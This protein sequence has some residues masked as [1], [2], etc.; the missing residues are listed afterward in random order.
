MRYMK[1]TLCLILPLVSLLCSCSPGIQVLLD[2]YNSMFDLTA[3]SYFSE[4]VNNFSLKSQYTTAN[5]STLSISAP[6]G[7]TSYEWLLAPR[8]GGGSN[9]PQNF[10]ISKYGGKTKDLSINLLKA[11]FPTEAPKG[12]YDLTL[13]FTH[14][15]TQH[16]YE[17][18][19]I[20]YE[21]GTGPI[22]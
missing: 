18:Q 12:T 21:P 16:E 1:T 20:V 3:S 14:G 22:P 19:V 2:D 13:K 7:G 11:N 8:E 9:L 6:A 15:G 5:N 4:S 10:D 17:S